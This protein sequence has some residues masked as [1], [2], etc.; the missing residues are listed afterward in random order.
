M[1]RSACTECDFLQVSSLFL[2]PPSHVQPAR[3][4]AWKQAPLPGRPKTFWL[5]LCY[6]E[7]R[8]QEGLL[9]SQLG[10]RGFRRWEVTWASH[11]VKK[12]QKRNFSKMLNVLSWYSKRAQ[13]VCVLQAWNS[14]LLSRPQAL[15]SI[16]ADCS[17]PCNQRLQTHHCLGR[18]L[19]G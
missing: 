15:P 2:L 1:Q 3:S 5:P 6:G 18:K 19:M 8:R 12:D 7:V 9:L 16:L 13:M 14:R 11:A 4:F 17:H 10:T